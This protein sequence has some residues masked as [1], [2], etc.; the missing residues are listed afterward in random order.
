MTNIKGLIEQSGHQIVTG[1]VGE[2][3]SKYSRSRIMW[4]SAFVYFGID[5]EY[6]LLMLKVKT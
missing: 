4:N 2:S 6:I 3:P 5:A 1:L